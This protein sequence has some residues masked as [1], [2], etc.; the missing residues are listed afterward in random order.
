[1]LDF[2]TIS[3]FTSVA[4][5]LNGKEIH[6]KG[7]TVHRIYTHFFIARKHFHK[8]RYSQGRKNINTRFKGWRD[9]L[10]GSTKPIGR[11]HETHA[12]Q[13]RKPWP[14]RRKEMD[15]CSKRETCTRKNRHGDFPFTAAQTAS[16]S[17]RQS[18]RRQLITPFSSLRDVRTFSRKIN[19][20]IILDIILASVNFKITRFVET[21]PPFVIRCMWPAFD[22]SYVQWGRLFKIPPIYI[23]WRKQIQQSKHRIRLNL[24]KTMDK[25]WH[26]RSEVFTAVTIKNGVFWDVTP[27]SFCN[28]RRF[29]GTYRLQH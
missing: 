5:R 24:S 25:V 1:M 20:K 18:M 19:Y 29:G 27:C 11:S 2:Q 26:V 15:P 22:S 17:V 7:T 8:M 6:R 10:Q 16:S 21:E 4:A 23:S 3:T 12:Q 9:T 14:S 13:L 28:N